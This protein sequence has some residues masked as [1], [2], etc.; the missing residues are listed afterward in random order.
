MI[1][2]FA[3]IPFDLTNGVR[4]VGGPPTLAT[5][6]TAQFLHASV[7]H[8][9][10]NMLFLAAFGP[11][12]EYAKGPFRFLAFYLFCGVAGAVAQVSIDPGSHVPEIGASGAIAGVLGAYI[13]RFPHAPSFLRIPAFVVMHGFG[14]LAANVLSERGGGTAYF[15]HIGGFLAGVFAS[16]FRPAT[17]SVRH[18]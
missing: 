15:A 6:V 9:A 18:D 2:R 12:L 3:T 8:I 4:V 17:A 1:S 16:A 5:L 11:A 7:P 13:V 10:F 14:S